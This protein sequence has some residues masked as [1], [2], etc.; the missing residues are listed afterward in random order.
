[1]EVY[2][3][4]FQTSDSEINYEKLNSFEPTIQKLVENRQ[5][6]NCDRCILS[7]EFGVI[8]YRNS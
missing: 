4:L 1:M 7:A 5:V 6:K 8:S 3:M 2:E